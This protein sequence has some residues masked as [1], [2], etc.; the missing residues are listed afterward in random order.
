MANVRSPNGERKPSYKNVIWFTVWITPF[1]AGSVCAMDE[2]RYLEAVGQQLR[3]EIAAAGMSAA[4]VA[5][6]LDMQKSQLHRYLHAQRDL[7]I[8]T[9]MRIA[10]VLGVDVTVILDRA[11]ERAG[12]SV[13]GA[14]D[15]E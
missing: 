12:S 5:R 15:T 7:P 6:E 11:D 3:A 10:R 8:S 9:L 2:Q 13:Q 4:Q 14:G 1:A